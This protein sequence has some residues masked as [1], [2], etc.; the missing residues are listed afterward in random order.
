MSV[1]DVDDQHRHPQEQQQ[2]HPN[3][4]VSTSATTYT[5]YGRWLIDIKTY[6][7][8][9]RKTFRRKRNGLLNS[10]LFNTII[11]TVTINY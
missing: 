2:P 9:H 11:N 3:T 7:H 4:N 1:G 8:F 6:H 10:F 5:T